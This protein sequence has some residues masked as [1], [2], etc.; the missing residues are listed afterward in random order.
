MKDLK[1][2]KDMPALLHT[3]SQN[4][5]L[6]YP[7]LVSTA[8]ENFLRVDGTPKIDKEKDTIR[9]VPQGARTWPDRRRDARRPRVA[10]K[11]EAA[12]CSRER[13]N[14]CRSAIPEGR[15]EALARTVISSIPASRTSAS[16]RTTKPSKNLLAMTHRS[17]LPAAI[18]AMRKRARSKSSPTAAWN[19]APAASCSRRA[20]EIT[21]NYPRGGYG[22][23]FK[24]G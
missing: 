5:F 7:Q 17:A 22:V 11:V 4:L 8:M 16:R 23:L 9:R 10:L 6:T 24:F 19:A 20:G 3:Q 15:R 18:R 1:K 14:G 2:Y 13:Q 21:W 12:S